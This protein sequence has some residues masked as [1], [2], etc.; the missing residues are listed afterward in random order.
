MNYSAETECA[1]LVIAF[2]CKVKTCSH[3]LSSLSSRHREG[4]PGT[5]LQAPL[6]CQPRLAVEL[7]GAMGEGGGAALSTEGR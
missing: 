7:S 2:D 5:G 6:C 1:S 3:S 4:S